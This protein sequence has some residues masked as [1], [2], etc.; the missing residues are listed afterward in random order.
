MPKESALES[1]LRTLV[2][3][4]GGQTLRLLPT[5]AGTPDRMVLLPD[6]RAFLVEL[7]ADGG[8]LRP[9]QRL[10]HERSAERGWPVTV[11]TGQQEVENWVSWTFP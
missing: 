11:L 6:G 1:R 10:W 2:R 5:V 7:K 3:E 4:R 9:V 8:S